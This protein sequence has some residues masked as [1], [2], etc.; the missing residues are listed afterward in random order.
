MYTYKKIRIIT[1]SIGC[2]FIQFYENICFS[3][4]HDLNI[5]ILIGDVLTQF[6]SYC[7]G[8]IFFFGIIPMATW[9]LSTM[10]WIDADYF[11]FCLLWA[12]GTDERPRYKQKGNHSGYSE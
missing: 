7:Q 9:I 10:A 6:E 8:Y 5:R 4:I 2:P 3:G 11:N 1:I 12:I